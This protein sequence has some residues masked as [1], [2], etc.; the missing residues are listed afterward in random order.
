M[1]HSRFVSF[2][3]RVAHDKSMRERGADIPAQASEVLL[4]QQVDQLAA[5]I[6]KSKDDTNE[7][8]GTAKMAHPSMFRSVRIAQRA[9]PMTFGGTPVQG[10]GINF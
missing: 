3:L 6:V 9:F 10:P 8:Q 1:L 5:Q 2:L 4:L 7:A